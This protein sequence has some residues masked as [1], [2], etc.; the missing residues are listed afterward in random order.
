MI[1]QKISKIFTVIGEAATSCGRDATEIK[2][3]GV[4]KTQPIEMIREA[5]EAGLMD[6]GENYVEDFSDKCQQ[7][8]HATHSYIL[9]LIRA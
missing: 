2:L 4:T 5:F 8:R 9:V 1:S 3:I 7:C 6:V